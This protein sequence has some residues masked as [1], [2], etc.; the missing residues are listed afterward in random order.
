MIPPNLRQP[1]YLHVVLN[2]L[3]TI[4]LAMGGLALLIAL[5]SR[6]T[7]RVSVPPLCIIAL[8]AFAIWPVEETGEKAYKLIRAQLDD[9]GVDWLEAHEERAEKVIPAF[10][11]LGGLSLAALFLPLKFPKA[12]KPLDI[13]VLILTFGCLAAG[14]WA[15]DAGGKIKHKEFR[16]GPPPAS[17]H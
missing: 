5:L 7:R 2:H 6:G 11:V 15:A 17:D 12:G 3:P 9:A 1:E 10:F 8:C 14:I 16:Y 4:G 13:A